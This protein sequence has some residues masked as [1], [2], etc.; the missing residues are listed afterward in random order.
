MPRYIDADALKLGI[1]K[2]DEIFCTPVRPLIID[3]I[4]N[5]PTAD[6]KIEI[7]PEKDWIIG[8]SHGVDTITCP[9]CTLT[10]N[11]KGQIDLYK[12]Y[13][14]FCPYCGGRRMKR[15]IEKR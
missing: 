15:K 2:N 4:D 14:R 13:F 5:T 12:N 9:E 6:V 3:L 1:N 11:C 7:K 8:W 10:I